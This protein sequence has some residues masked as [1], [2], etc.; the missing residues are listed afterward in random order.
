MTHPHT[1]WKWLAAN[2]PTV[3]LGCGLG[4]LGVRPADFTAFLGGKNILT[5]NNHAPG[6]AF[7]SGHSYVIAGI[8]LLS[9]AAISLRRSYRIQVGWS[10]ACV[11]LLFAWISLRSFVEAKIGIGGM[12]E[13]GGGILVLM[14]AATGTPKVN[15]TAAFIAGTLFLAL[16]SY[17]CL[18]GGGGW[19]QGR[20]YGV[21]GHPNHM[22][23]AA[24]VFAVI[25]FM[26]VFE[27]GTATAK[28]FRAA[29]AIGLIILTVNSG[30]RT[31]LLSLASALVLLVTCASGAAGWRIRRLAVGVA[32]LATMFALFLSPPATSDLMGEGFDRGNTRQEAWSVMASTISENPMLG[33]GIEK[34]YV[35]SSYL[36]AWIRGGLPAFLL[37]A[38]AVTLMWRGCF[39][40]RKC[41]IGMTCLCTAS[42][43]ITMGIFEGT[44][45]DKFSPITLV[46]GFMLAAGDRA[47]RSVSYYRSSPNGREAK[48]SPPQHSHASFLP[49]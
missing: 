18:I 31:A 23:A 3:I 25:C 28:I 30:S 45:L 4:I 15:L 2:L 33:T 14:I 5:T 39:H 10:T 34:G 42:A 48:L 20:M 21:T 1:I 37:L 16:N 22:G 47:R 35:E 7:L 36:L 6:I 8:L 19:W 17:E 13:Y 29:I 26:R 38:I 44:L 46:L 40:G 43:L 41:L 49:S 11:G 27:E 24:V 12:A 32:C 9:Y